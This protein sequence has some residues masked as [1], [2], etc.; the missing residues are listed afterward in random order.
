LL[1]GMN[2]CAAEPGLES[3]ENPG[4][5]SGQWI[6]FCRDEVTFLHNEGILIFSVHR[7]ISTSGCKMEN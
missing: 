1:E 3:C 6:D 2:L 5:K 7:I 4:R